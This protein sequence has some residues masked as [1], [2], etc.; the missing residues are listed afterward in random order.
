[1]KILQHSM[2]NPQK[3]TQSSICPSV[4]GCMNGTSTCMY[5]Y[6]FLSV[7]ATHKAGLNDASRSNAPSVV[8][9]ASAAFGT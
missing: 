5:L 8:A 9:A 4:G 3:A 7:C 6:L 1:M 2:L